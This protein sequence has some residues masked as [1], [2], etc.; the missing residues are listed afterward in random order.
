MWVSSSPPLPAPP[1]W[2]Q[3]PN[4]HLSPYACLNPPLPLGIPISGG[5]WCFLFNHKK[6]ITRHTGAVYTCRSRGCLLR[7]HPT[8]SRH[9]TANP[10]LEDFCS[11]EEYYLSTAHPSFLNFCGFWPRTCKKSWKRYQKEAAPLLSRSLWRIRP[12]A[13]RN[14]KLN[15]Y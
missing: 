10:S 1:H 2:Q 8:W 9:W 15:I 7:A 5:I 12:A 4:V 3:D 13:I 6:L 14:R 11:T